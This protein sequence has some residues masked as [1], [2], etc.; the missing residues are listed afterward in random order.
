[1]TSERIY[2][3]YPLGFTGA[4]QN[5]NDGVESQNIR[6]IID[7]IPHL[8]SLEITVLLLGPVFESESHGYDTADYSRVDRRLGTKED[9]RSLVDAC[10]Q[11]GIQVMLDCVFNHVARSH[12]IFQEILHH[13]E[14]ASHTSWVKGLNFSSNN[15][16]NDGFSYECWDGHEQLVKLDLTHVEVRDWLTD[17]ALGWLNDYDIDGL[18]MDAADVM[19]KAFLSH[20]SR[21]LKNVKKG[22]T[23]LGEVVH[24]DYNQW[25][26]EGGLDA[27]TN[28]E[29]YKGLY[30]SLNDQ[31][32]YEIGYALNRQFGKGGLYP[33]KAMVNF[34]DNHDVNRVSSMLKDQGHLY[35]LYIMLYTIPGIPALYYGSEFAHEGVKAPT[36]D[37]PLRPSWND[38]ATGNKDLYEVL[39]KLGAINRDHTA[40]QQGGYQ[41]VHIDHQVIGYKRQWPGKDVYVFINAK[42]EGV[43]IPAPM[44]QG[45]YY[46]ALNEENYSTQ[47]SVQIHPNWGRILV[48]R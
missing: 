20:L 36:N 39:T 27:V 10:H 6:S 37:N 34:A 29:T 18:R 8:Q 25:L 43:T 11:A 42:K 3:L 13:R 32:Y 40:I 31:N 7:L 14:Q 48:R 5:Y 9:L 28:Y 30:S 16:N 23:L 1:M 2:H 22:F 17:T 45:D 24:G 12:F 15:R 21:C 47:G 26:S 46:D 44:I 19:D 4:N 41:Q 33:A 35:P 38:V